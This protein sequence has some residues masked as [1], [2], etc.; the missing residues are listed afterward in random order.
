LAV[1]GRLIRIALRDS[2]IVKG[3]S[4]AMWGSK[5]S[6]KKRP[7]AVNPANMPNYLSSGSKPTSP[8]ARR[9]SVKV[10]EL[11]D[12]IDL[13]G[14]GVLSRDEVVTCAKMIDMNEQEAGAFFDQLDNRKKGELNRKEWDSG[15]EAGLEKFM[16]AGK[17]LKVSFFWTMLLTITWPLS[18]RYLTPAG[19]SLLGV[20][21]RARAHACAGPR[22]DREEAHR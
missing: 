13:N 10:M 3:T 14:D 18:L 22:R 7:E 21:A 8:T 4:R 9:N 5:K 15:A 19:D 2:A 12:K 6:S 1:P 17:S 11:F 20:C 16:H